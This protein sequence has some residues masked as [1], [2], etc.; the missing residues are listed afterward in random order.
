VAQKLVMVT[1]DWGR[2]GLIAVVG[3]LLLHG[4]L[5]PGLY[6]P[7]T[8]LLAVA[9]LLFSPAITAVF[10]RV[11]PPEHLTRA[12]GVWSATLAVLNVGAYAVGGGVVALV[13]PSGALL[14]DA[15]TF[16]ISGALLAVVPLPA[17]QAS[18]SDRGMWAF[19]HDSVA[20]VRDLWHDRY[21][22]R[23][24]L[25]VGPMN[26]VFGP[27]QVFSLV[28][29]R[30]VL[31][32]GPVSYGAIEAASG[33]GSVAAG[34]TV[35]RVAP[36][37]TLRGWVRA[38]ALGAGTGLAAVLLWP[39]LA[40]A[41]GVYGLIWFLSAILSIPFVSSVQRTAAPETVG[42]VMQSLFLLTGG[43][44]VPLG[45]VLG[46]LA[47]DHWGALT[48]LGGQAL[49]FGVLGVVSWFVALNPPPEHDLA[50]EYRPP[51]EPQAPAP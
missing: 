27:L 50:Q 12:N 43:V 1:T 28:F 18:P 23:V 48:A 36:W 38:V 51:G 3:L 19:L 8:G 41:I 13:H 42:R 25:I 9:G 5:W 16:V 17:I 33:L 22:R 45:L 11:V 39:N 32:G 40:L 30:V 7:V 31:H 14:L 49:L 6:Y 35:S 24:I 44:T 10:P 29:S 21:L 34:L 20:G 26:M 15:A 4:T 47:M 46:S 2:A 37:L